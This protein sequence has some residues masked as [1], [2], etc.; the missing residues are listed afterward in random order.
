MEVTRENNYTVSN[1][2]AIKNPIRV[3]NTLGDL[4]KVLLEIRSH[5]L[6]D[7]S[8]LWIEFTDSR[9]ESFEV[10][11]EWYGSETIPQPTLDISG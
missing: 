6:P 11:A 2:I 5:G 10:R 8:N 1:F 3:N 7:D 9:N 4:M